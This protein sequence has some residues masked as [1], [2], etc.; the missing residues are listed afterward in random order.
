M[1]NTSIILKLLASHI[2]LT[3]YTHNKFDYIKILL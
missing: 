3:A 2:F 1:F